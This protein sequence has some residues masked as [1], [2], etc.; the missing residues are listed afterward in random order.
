[1]SPISAKNTTANATTRA[2][3]RA[4]AYRRLVVAR[5]TT[6]AFALRATTVGAA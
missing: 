5:S 1:L 2:D 6:G 4:R 3:T